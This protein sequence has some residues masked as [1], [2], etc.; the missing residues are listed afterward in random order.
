MQGIVVE[1]VLIVTVLIRSIFAR[2]K[3]HE[4]IS[5]SAV[6]PAQNRTN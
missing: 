6:F 3:M 1:H 5:A 2:K 4:R